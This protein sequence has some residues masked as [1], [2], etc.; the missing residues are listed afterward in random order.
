MAV[1]KI[2]LNGS[3]AVIEGAN[4]SF[5]QPVEDTRISYDTPTGKVSFY[6]ANNPS[7]GN[8]PFLE[9][10]YSDFSAQDGVQFA[11]LSAAK[12]YL[13]T[14]FLK[15]SVSGGGSFADLEGEPEDNP[16]LASVLD[17]KQD[18]L[19]VA[20]QVAIKVLDLQQSSNGLPTV[21]TTSP[22]ITLVGG[23]T[24]PIASATLTVATDYTK[25]NYLAS[26]PRAYSPAGPGIAFVY[27]A[28]ATLGADGR[29]PGGKQGWLMKACFDTDADVIAIP[30]QADNNIAKTYRVWVDGQ[31]TATPPVLPDFEFQKLVINFGSSKPRKIMIEF[32][33]FV[34][35]GGVE[36]GPRYSVW[37]QNPDDFRAVLIGDSYS[38]GTQG[39]G[40]VYPIQGFVNMISNLL[41]VTDIINSSEGGM[42]YVT[43]GILSVKNAIQKLDTDVTPYAPNLIIA[44]LGYND[45]AVANAT[46]QAAVTAFWTKALTDNPNSLCIAV[47]PFRSPSNTAAITPRAAF[48]KAGVEAVAGFGTRLFYIDTIAENWQSGTGRVGATQPTGNSSIYI[49]ADNVHSVQV[50]QPYAADRVF[51]GMLN[52]FNS[53]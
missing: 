18:K 52:I 5:D 31:I 36:V 46:L 51:Q 45:G 37:K 8:A 40:Q 41:G 38:A 22:T 9:G 47:G 30:I 24:S 21:M 23:Y 16:A 10:L 25:I 12:A 26:I 6:S 17:A 14:V 27:P 50:F 39:D 42:G 49:G 19:S 3:F 33:Q 35:F 32:E 20:K 2:Y 11:S 28:N 7:L 1:T 29:N 34:A 15:P 13:R 43:N 48:I 44:P 53:L 4:T